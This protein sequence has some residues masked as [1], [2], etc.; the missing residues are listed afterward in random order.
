MAEL[1]A[2]EK[3][4]RYQLVE[5]IGQGGIT[6]VYV[7]T[8]TAFHRQVVLKVLH[9]HLAQNVEFKERFRREIDTL[10][11][12]QHPNIV[13]LYDM[14]E[15]DALTYLVT[16]YMD[17]G[18]L[19]DAISRAVR[20]GSQVEMDYG[21]QIILQT[22]NGLMHAHS[23]N[24]I[25]RDVKPSNILLSS[26]GRAAIGDFGV[27]LYQGQ[28][29]QTAIGTTLGTP[30]YMAPEQ[31]RAEAA[32]ARTD[33][34][35][36]GVV[37]F[38]VLTG[39][40]PFTGNGPMAIIVKVIQEPPPSP[41]QFNPLVTP[42]LEAVVIKA[43]AKNPD[44]RFQTMADF[45]AALDAAS[46]NLTP[47]ETI[48]REFDQ[49]QDRP[50]L[51]K[52]LLADAAALV[53]RL[54]G[55]ESRP[56]EHQPDDQVNI[57]PEETP[58]LQPSFLDEDEA[59]SGYATTEILPH[60]VG[61]YPITA[62]LAEE[63]GIAWLLALSGPYRG[64]QFQIKDSVIIGRKTFE[65]T[66]NDHQVSQNHARIMLQDGRFLIEDLNSTNGTMVN[67]VPVLPRMPQPLQDRDEIRIGRTAMI[68]IQA[69]RPE[70]ATGKARQR[71]KEFDADWDQLIQSFQE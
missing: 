27:A 58:S 29:T 17:G 59:L 26:S 10:A 41:R 44:D 50:G 1:R 39:K 31:V 36:L 5:Q 7:A 22:A 40:R 2:G 66:E 52:R 70:D 21:L 28:S 14:G 68:F 8:D 37:L 24:V 45:H 16:E 9:P 15:T 54:T 25:H 57:P 61:S 62:P 30:L 35:A 32:D 49:Q 20:Q 60:D 47:T 13:T 4:G 46:R 43:L 67:S 23:Q 55:T 3:I 48:D 56:T 34:Y 6:A 12:L 71:L 38:E 33:V 63:A 18:S 19:A 51:F 53:S 65:L 64:R 42:A 11:R 69:V